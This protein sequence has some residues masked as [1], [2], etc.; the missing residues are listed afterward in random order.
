LAVT[1]ATEVVCP[2]MLL[3]YKNKAKKLKI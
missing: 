1:A 2:T 3:N